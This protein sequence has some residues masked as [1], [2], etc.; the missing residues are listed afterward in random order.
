M[1]AKRDLQV[2]HKTAFK[3]LNELAN[4]KTEKGK[5]I[6]IYGS[7]AKNLGISQSTVINY[8]AGRGKDGYLTDA[9]IEQFQSL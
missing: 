6:R 7:V 3:T 1:K 2:R 5:V 8:L 9:L 4:A